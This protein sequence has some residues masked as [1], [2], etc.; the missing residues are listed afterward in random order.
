DVAVDPRLKGEIGRH[1]RA[2]ARRPAL[3]AGAGVVV[4][5]R[6][7]LVAGAEK[8]RRARLRKA[9]GERP[10]QHGEA[11]GEPNG[12]R[13]ARADGGALNLAE[14]GVGAIGAAHAVGPTKLVALA[15]C[16]APVLIAR[17]LV[18]VC[19]R[20]RARIGV[21]RDRSDLAGIADRS[22]G[23]RAGSDD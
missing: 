15:A 12:R 5:A 23:G 3:H 16:V 21:L 4:T 7:R 18:L 20:V 13:D 6:V 10:V 9:F 14:L 1:A 17:E 11:L 2:D 19:E 22:T 8:R